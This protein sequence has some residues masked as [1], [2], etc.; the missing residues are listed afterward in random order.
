MRIYFFTSKLNFRTAGG[1]IEEFDLMMRTLQKR[2]AEVTCVTTFSDGNDI[3][4]PLP[5]AVIEEDIKN[6]SL[7]G[8]SWG[9]Y[10]LL[11]KYQEN[12][13]FF[14][15]D[16]HNFL[17][18]AGAYRRF[19][20]RVPVSAYFNREL[21]SF[22]PDRSFL[23][24]K[25]SESVLRKVR[26]GIRWILERTFGMY[27]ARS[28][29]LREFISPMYRR[30]Y[31]NFGL[32]CRDNCM[33]LPDPI[34]LRA[35]M[36]ENGITEYSYRERLKRDGR[37][38][39]FF[40]SRMAPAKGFDLILAGFSRLK[41]K[42]KYHLILGG[43]GPEEGEIKRLA[44]EL[45]IMRHIEFPGWTPK[46]KLYEYYKK[47]DMFVQVGWREEGTSVSLLYA[48]AFGLPSIVRRGSGIA[49]QAGDAALPVTHGDREALAQAIER[50]GEDPDLRAHLSRMCYERLFADELNYE[51]NISQWLR[52]MDAI[53]NQSTLLKKK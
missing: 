36:R 12:A 24:G 43:D 22:P 4:G 5:Y 30:M 6:R 17:Y 20:G 33:V 21:G 15:V 32:T 23:I 48:L 19:G 46:E 38:T 51:K 29:D 25:N 7:F 10:N 45:G 47:A 1:S 44:E 13:D 37:L 27:L 52:A 53:A 28:L 16:G 14:H 39:I 35:I 49:W 42:D 8:T 40:S 9:I 26:R 50:L 18:G 31:E 2:G 3:Q 34:D 11:K 41:N